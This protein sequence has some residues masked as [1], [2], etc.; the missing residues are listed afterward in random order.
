MQRTRFLTLCA[1]ALV[2]AAIPAAALA[3]SLP[4]LAGGESS[5]FSVRPHYIELSVDGALYIGG[6]KSSS[7]RIGSI[8]WSSWGSSRARGTGYLWVDNCNPNCASGRYKGHKVGISASNVRNGDFRRIT[9]SCTVS[10]RSK[11]DTLTLGKA[12][13]ANIWFWNHGV[14]A[15]ER[16]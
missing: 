10:G 4:K 16:A 11:S 3:A 9:L 7:G 5:R 14:L 12:I 8:S 2:A 6:S 15:C 1:V 13:N